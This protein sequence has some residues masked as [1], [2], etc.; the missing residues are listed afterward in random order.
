M[1]REFTSNVRVAAGDDGDSIDLREFDAV[2]VV[3]TEALAGD[4]HVSDEADDNFSAA[5]TDDLIARTGEG[6]A[7]VTGYTGGKRYLKVVGDDA[8]QAVVI[9][10]YLG[11]APQGASF[12]R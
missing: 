10:Y 6:G 9:G 4:I 11:R 7:N 1:N 8:D 5:D 2:I 3:S 12:S